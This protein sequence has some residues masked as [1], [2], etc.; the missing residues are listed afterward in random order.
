MYVTSMYTN[1]C[2][3]LHGTGGGKSHFHTLLVYYVELLSE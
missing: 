3:D 1:K 2:T